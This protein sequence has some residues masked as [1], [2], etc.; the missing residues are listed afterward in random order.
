MP[1]SLGLQ[2]DH[3]EILAPLGK[4]GM[5]EVY[6]AKD[7][8]LN[9]EVAIK[10]LPGEV[11]HDGERLRRFETEA[12]AV[13]TL[14]HPN[15]LTVHDFGSYDGNPFIVME[16]LEG[17]ELRA[18]LDNGALPVRK[19]VEYAQQIATGL[20]AAHAKNI[21]HRDLKPANIFV[22]NDGRVKILDFG[23]AKL[24]KSRNT[25]F[26]MRNEEAD[27]LIQGEANIP[28]S[29]IRNPH[30]TDPGVVMGT[31]GYMSPEQVNGQVA[32]HRSDIFSFGVILYE[33]LS[34][35][36]AFTG[37]SMVETMH[38]ILKDE[39]P[40]LSETN[41]KISPALDRIVRRC[42]EKKPEL[43]FQTASDLSFALSTL[44]TPS[45][46]GSNRTEAAPALATTAITPRSSKRERLAWIGFGVASLL[47]LLAFGTTYF[48]RP[49][50]EAEP[51][52][53]SINA[54]EKATFYDWPTISPDG[55]TLA[56]VA[57]VQGKRQLWVRPLNTT[58][59][60][61]LVEV[62]SNLP[63]PFWSPDSQFIAYFDTIKLKKIALAGDTPETLCEVS[64][65]NG[66]T[67]SREGVI[68]FASGGS[69]RRVS[70]NGGAVTAV[71]SVDT[72][73]GETTH[74]AP[75]FLPDG[76][77]FLYHVSNL[78]LA[79]NGV[80]L[81]ALEGGETRQLLALE[82]RTVGVAVSPAVPREGYLTFVREGALLV[83]PFDF[84]RNQL[85]GNPVRVAD[86]VSARTRGLEAIYSLA[87]NGA[88][89]L[90][91]KE[92]DQQLTWFDRA[93]KKLGTVGATGQY[94][95]PKLSPDGQRLAVG[96]ASPQTQ[97]GDIH[98]FD[99][100]GGAGTP[101]TFDPRHDECPRWSP[102]GSRLVWISW[103]EGVATLFQ[104]A[105][106]G[107][108]QDEVLLRSAQRKDTLDW[109]ADGRFMLYTEVGAQT[110]GDIWVLPLEGE[111]KPW[112]WLNTPA[113]ETAATI[114]PDGKWIAYASDE[115]GP[116][117]IYRDQ[118]K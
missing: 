34:G 90:R 43:R 9:R 58:T 22:T 11:A 48:R 102:D 19:A 68:L 94:F 52:R 74:S 112:V 117:E 105:A 96:R 101:F 53:F 70:A 40:E 13:G 76:R 71:T 29:A 39:P 103:R 63:H 62:P 78:D 38:K 56:F 118:E 23:L 3:Y 91:E 31:V 16:L 50:L 115:S 41:A 72:A 8:R 67:W 10:I 80:Y 64:T 82:T 37:S 114:S 108:G 60:R 75:V 59:A 113:F 83:Q 33:M 25:E 28:Q 85:V 92:A 49:T 86:R 110:A 79:K 51:M 21:V 55:R 7:T 97:F 26:G 44:T 15:I 88:L 24:M 106:S 2:F 57:E 42:L 65:R 98:L 32:D 36:R 109:S 87:T 12:R 35:Q 93:G 66:G 89:I 47:A 14:N 107:V 99:L 1:I 18:Q 81:A 95:H 77:H 6:R 54:P 4:G 104:K 111:R 46:S 100:P 73:R 27:T 61:P 69:I 5:G 116:W 20:S 30:S 17:E 84:S 45:S